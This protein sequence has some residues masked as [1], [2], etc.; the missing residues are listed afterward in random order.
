MIQA[1]LIAYWTF[2]C[3]AMMEA[4]YNEYQADQRTTREGNT[5]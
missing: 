1:M 2:L 3:N 4:Y 5:S